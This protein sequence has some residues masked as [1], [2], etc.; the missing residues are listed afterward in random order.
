MKTVLLGFGLL[1]GVITSASAA[2]FGTAEEA[3]ALVKKAIAHI[4]SVGPEKAYADF[5]GKKLDFVNK[6][7]Y[8]FVNEIKG[9]TLAHGANE[10][11]VGKNMLDL[12]DVDG[13]AFLNEISEKAKVQSS[14]SVD[15]KFTD[16]VTKKILPK[17]IFC[18]RLA[19]TAVCSG[20]Y[21]R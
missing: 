8:V 15:Y 20:I 11:L 21:K 18:E 17:T 7:L 13:K 2:E 16:P 1:F 10:K 12:K 4:Q 9:N 5:T 19:E 6:D 14:F 3:Q